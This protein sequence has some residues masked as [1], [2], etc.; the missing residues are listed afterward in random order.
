MRR[1]RNGRNR[2]RHH[3]RATW[4]GGCCPVAGL[5]A[6]PLGHRKPLALCSGSDPRRGCLPHPHRSRPGKSGCLS[7][8]HRFH[9]TPGW[10]Q[11]YRCRTPHMHLE[12][13]TTPRQ[14]GHSEKVIV[15]GPAPWPRLF[16][17]LRASRETELAEKYPVQVV[18]SWMGNTPNVAMRHYLMTNDEHF[19]SAVKGDEPPTE[20]APEEATEKAAQNAAQSAHAGHRRDSHEQSSAHEKPRTL[21]GLAGSCDLTQLPGM[22]GTGFEPATSRL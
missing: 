13:S 6:W 7:Q 12:N 1:C 17:N 16:Q 9:A 11:Q 8:G 22:A 3:Q 10:P 18:T 2:L 19:A 14:T 15:P 21:P 20:V 5:V 4:P